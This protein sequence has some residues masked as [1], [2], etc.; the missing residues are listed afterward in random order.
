MASKLS[1]SLVPLFSLGLA[2]C[3]LH[4]CGGSGNGP[5]TAVTTVRVYAGGG[6]DD[7]VEAVGS[8]RDAAVLGLKFALGGR[9]AAGQPLTVTVRFTPHADLAH[10]L[11]RLHVDN[12]IELRNGAE[13]PMLD[14]PVRDV[15]VDES[16]VV[17][18]RHAGVYTLSVT[19]TSDGDAASV[20]RT[21]SIPLIVGP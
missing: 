9:P 11:A 6:G 15:A 17:T 5:A 21:F 1:S 3:G 2:C 8:N 18:P 14:H 16:F 13:L 19:V 10:I 12:E 7:M 20:S 4:A